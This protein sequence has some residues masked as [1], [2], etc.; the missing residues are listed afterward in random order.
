MTV[1]NTKGK[2]PG[3]GVRGLP[4]PKEASAQGRIPG[5]LLHARELKFLV[6]PPEGLERVGERSQ[7]GPSLRLIDVGRWGG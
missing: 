6:G 1:L 7:M 3:A 2:E 5:T 4:V